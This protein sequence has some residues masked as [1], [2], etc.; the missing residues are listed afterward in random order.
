VR[1]DAWELAPAL[2]MHVEGDGWRPQNEKRFHWPA[3]HA[4]V[5]TLVAQNFG[6]G[7]TA[8]PP[9]LLKTL[10]DA[11]AATELQLGGIGKKKRDDVFVE[12]RSPMPMA[13]LGALQ[14]EVRAR[15]LLSEDALSREGAHRV[16]LVPG[17]VSLGAA[18]E[19][20]EGVVV[21]DTDA[22]SMLFKGDTRGVALRALLETQ[23]RRLISFQTV[24]ELHA[25]ILLRHFSE[26]RIRRLEAMLAG[27]EV[28]WPD[29]LTCL[30]WAQLIDHGR[31]HG[32]PTGPQDA[33]VAAT[34]LRHGARVCTNNFKDYDYLPG[35]RFLS[36][37]SRQAAAGPGTQLM[38][39]ERGARWRPRGGHF[40][41]G[42]LAVVVGSAAAFR[43]CK[44]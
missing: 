36:P 10:G 25:W 34:A 28:I 2:E 32:R 44:R 6:P 41:L 31:A 5:P 21:V 40:A 30:L 23:D 35:M 19:P 15:L 29:H 7:L 8:P 12:L 9:E 42:A 16:E 13:Q 43:L 11:V 26:D 39:C 22:L 4:L 27:Y 24:A 38:Q 37:D 17:G 33:W 1:L 3:K 18:A 14:L 20:Q